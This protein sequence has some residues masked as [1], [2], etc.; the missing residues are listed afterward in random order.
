MDDIAA[1]I[2][3]YVDAGS[4][5]KSL[6]FTASF[7][8]CASLR[9]PV[10]VSQL[11]NHLATIFMNYP[12]STW[13][14]YQ[15]SRNSNLT[16]GMIM[17]ARSAPWDWYAVSANE[18]MTMDNI[19]STWPMTRAERKLPTKIPW[20]FIGLSHNDNIEAWFIME[21]ANK[22][23]WYW[24]SRNS[25]ITIEVVDAYNKRLDFNRSYRWNITY[26]DIIARPQYKWK[27]GS[28]GL[29]LYIV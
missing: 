9:M 7:F 2:L 15:L 19:W 20:S 23:D 12:S 1:Q 6:V 11:T 28:L 8:Y 18:A 14:Y 25:H 22:L 21:Y 10:R 24:I 13:V 27:K 17:A 3:S 16:L 5:W 26:Q 29:V 4:D